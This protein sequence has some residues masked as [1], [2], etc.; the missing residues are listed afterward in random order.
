[1]IQSRRKKIYGHWP[2]TKEL[3]KSWTT[4]GPLG[5]QNLRTSTQG[6][7]QNIQATRNELGKD[8]NPMSLAKAK[9]GLSHRIE[10][11]RMCTALIPEIQQSRG[12]VGK[13]RDRLTLEKRE[14]ALNS[15][16]DRAEPPMVD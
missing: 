7:H 15:I 5:S 11:G 13:Q 10:C 8:A 6:I 1:M 16:K 4:K 14:K 9:N 3:P 12:I 2:M